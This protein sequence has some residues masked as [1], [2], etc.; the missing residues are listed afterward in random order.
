METIK[1]AVDHYALLKKDGKISLS[2]IRAELK[3]NPTFSAAE[4][5]KICRIIS[6][7]ELDE[8]HEDKRNPLAFLSSIWLSY[9]LLAVFLYLTYK[10]YLAIED[11]NAKKELGPVDPKMTTWRYAM[12]VGSLF[13]VVRNIVRIIKHISKKRK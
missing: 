6:D 8:M 12:L 4:T 9:I 2:E 7:Q 1:E 13:F 3:E 11:L 5:S 10:S